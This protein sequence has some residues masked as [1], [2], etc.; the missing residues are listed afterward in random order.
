MFND[1]QPE[2][3]CVLWNFP[4]NGKLTQTHT[5]TQSEIINATKMSNIK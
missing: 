5:H 4:A 1:F 2:C 3:N